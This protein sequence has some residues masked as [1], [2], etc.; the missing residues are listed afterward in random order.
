MEDLTEQ[1]V[2]IRALGLAN[3]WATTRGAHLGDH[4]GTILITK[5]ADAFAAFINEGTVAE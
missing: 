5:V 3:D 2:R 1:Q 4:P